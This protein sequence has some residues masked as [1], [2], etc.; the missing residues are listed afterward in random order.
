[1]CPTT[2]LLDDGLTGRPFPAGPAQPG[3]RAA[4]TAA[5]LAC[6]EGA[7]L[8]VG[9]TLRTSQAKRESHRRTTAV[10][11]DMEAAGVAEA[12]TKLGIP[13]LAIKAVVDSV[14]EPLPE[15]LARCTTPEGDLR[16]GALLTS[17]LLSGRRQRTLLRLGRAS[18]QAGHGL[19]RSLDLL[20]RP[21]VALTAPGGS[22]RI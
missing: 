13:W 18:R 4:L 6:H 16:W 19:R 5:G 20:L 2:V 9:A 8:T 1:M 12:A 21:G 7:V 3:V 11:V 15:F 22:S 17:L 14:E 10:A